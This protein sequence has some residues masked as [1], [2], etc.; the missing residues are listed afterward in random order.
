MCVCA[1]VEDLVKEVCAVIGHLCRGEYIEVFR[2][3]TAVAL[4][5]TND[6]GDIP[7]T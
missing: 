2:Q 3:Q 1:F 7:G 6:N 4:L 5:G